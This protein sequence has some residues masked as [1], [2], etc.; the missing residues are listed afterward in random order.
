[1]KILFILPLSALSA[2]RRESRSQFGNV[3]VSDGLSG[4]RM[5]HDRAE[6]ADYSAGLRRHQH[7]VRIDLRHSVPAEFR[8]EERFALGSDRLFKAQMAQPVNKV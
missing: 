1:M 7:L 6:V 3:M 4:Q 2:G 5:K 8:N